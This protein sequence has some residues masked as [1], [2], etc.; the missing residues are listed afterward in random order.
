MQLNIWLES[1]NRTQTVYCF[2]HF[3]KYFQC[4]LRCMYKIFEILKIEN[5]W[6]T[7]C[8]N[9]K[10]YLSSFIICFK[11]TLKKAYEEY[12]YNMINNLNKSNCEKKKL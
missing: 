11:L 5:K 2:K 7:T 10:K 6:N 12:W 1:L 9:T 8:S 3:K 4:W